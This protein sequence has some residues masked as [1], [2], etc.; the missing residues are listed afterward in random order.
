VV[1]AVLA[2]YESAPVDEKLRGALHFLA[3]LDPARAF[4]AGV[5]RQALR[6]ALD[7]KAAFDLITRFADTIG[8]VPGSG[9]GLSHDDVLAGGARFYER[10]YVS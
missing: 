5:S 2:D 6:D 10:G 1:Q 8:A 3:T 4:A 9:K 7:V